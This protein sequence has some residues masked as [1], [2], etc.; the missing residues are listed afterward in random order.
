MESVM[1]TTTNADVNG[2]ETITLSTP[3]V[4]TEKPFF[5]YD[6]I[7]SSISQ[8]GKNLRLKP[9]DPFLFWNDVGE[10]WYK[11]FD[12]REKYYVSVAWLVDRLK[13][14]PDTKTLLEV[15]CGFGRLL[16]FLLKAGVTEKTEGIDIAPEILR[17]HAEYLNPEPTK[18][19]E[20]DRLALLVKQ[21]GLTEAQ[22]PVIEAALK[23]LQELSGE[24]PKPV[25]E[26]YRDRIM[27]KVGDAR[28]LDYAPDSFDCVLT[29]ELLQHLNPKDC[30]K[31]LEE[32][33]RVTSKLILCVERWGFPSEHSEAHIWSHNIAEMLDSIGAEV[34]QVTTVGAA[35]QGVVAVKRK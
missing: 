2:S 24:N 6:D 22:K 3:A 27:L 23:R 31:A 10:N 14:F 9:Y 30:R 1:T 13:Q 25:T 26:D 8:G 16:P 29:S 35:L 12:K 15:G 4:S 33:Y 18:L 17:F 19:T 28:K 5:S 21:D 34:L 7:M 11:T 32:M 20:L